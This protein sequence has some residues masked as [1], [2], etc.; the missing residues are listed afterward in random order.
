[1]ADV[2]VSTHIASARNDE[3][4]II[5][6]YDG[7]ENLIGTDYVSLLIEDDRLYF[8]PA[9]NKIKGSLKL[10][11]MINSWKQ[12]KDLQ[13]FEGEYPLEFS[14][15]RDMYY[16][17]VNKRSDISRTYGSNNVPHPNYKSHINESYVEDEVSEE[18]VER[19]YSMVVY[20]G[21]LE[22]LRIQIQD[23]NKSAV[24]D[25][26]NTIRSLIKSE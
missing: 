4:V 5:R 20:D 16:I 14:P 22:L 8:K 21:L 17:D 2:R 26:L 25:T 7:L 9:E 3:F 23:L 10:S 18:T 1:M 13:K 15:I 6:F 11:Y 24:N 12:S 19:K